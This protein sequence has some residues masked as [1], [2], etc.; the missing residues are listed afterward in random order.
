MKF[1]KLLEKLETKK[2]TGMDNLLSNVLKIAAG[3]QAPSLAL[4]DFL[5]QTEWKLARVTPIF[6]K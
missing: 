5:W 3:V 6:K 1:K 2:A 4:V